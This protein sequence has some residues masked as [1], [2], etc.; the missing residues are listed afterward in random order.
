[1]EEVETAKE[2]E[3]AAVAAQEQLAVAHQLVALV[4]LEEMVQQVV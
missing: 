2:M 4:P 1:M 3:A